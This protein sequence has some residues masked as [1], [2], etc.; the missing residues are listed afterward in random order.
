MT[1]RLSGSSGLDV[2]VRSGA[3]RGYCVTHATDARVMDPVTPHGRGRVCGPR[4]QKPKLRRRMS[5]R[6]LRDEVPEAHAP[7]ASSQSAGEAAL[8]RAATSVS[9]S[10]TYRL[11]M[12]SVLWPQDALETEGI[13]AIDEIRAR[14]GV[15]QREH[16][17]HMVW[18]GGGGRIRTFGLL[19]QSQETDFRPFRRVSEHDNRRVRASNFSESGYPP[20]KRSGD[21]SLRHLTLKALEL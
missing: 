9:A 11:T 7:R 4:R 21:H 20:D 8:W 18:T 1:V 15:A 5:D 19:I 6:A 2:V 14:E 3:R 12:S 10:A 17:A 16:E 13:A